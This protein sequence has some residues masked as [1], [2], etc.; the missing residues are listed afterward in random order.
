MSN[1]LPINFPKLSLAYSF[2]PN[3]TFIFY[4]LA[5]GK[6]NCGNLRFETV[7]KDVEAL[8]QSAATGLHDITKLSV[9]GFGHLRGSYAL[10][11]SGAALGRGCGPLLV[12]NPDFD[13]KL[14][15]TIPVAVPGMWTTARLLFGLYS[16]ESVE[17]VPM[18]FDQIMPAIKKGEFA[19]GV[20]IHEGRFTYPDYGLECLEDLGKWWENKTGLPIPLGVIA[21]RRTI[22]GK[23]AA[24]IESIIRESIE[25]SY[26]NPDQAIGYIRKH[27]QEFSPEVI[28]RHIQLYVNDFSFD[29]GKDGEKAIKTL[30]ALASKQ[31]FIAENKTPLFAT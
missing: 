11:R 24:T 12:A 20:I 15:Q 1:I 21:I 26:K 13:P 4:A 2:C 29:L 31:R 17:P 16:P 25:Y 3:D 30:F 9:A 28:S 18:R 27:A 14:L 7:L 8:N 19:A 10:L 5:H 6:I 22:S 23:I